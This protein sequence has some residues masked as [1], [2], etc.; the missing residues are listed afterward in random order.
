[1]QVLAAKDEDNA[2]SHA[3]LYGKHPKTLVSNAARHRTRSRGF[4]T[5]HKEPN[6]SGA[7]IARL[8]E[9]GE[10]GGKRG[11]QAA[12]GLVVF[13]KKEDKKKHSLIGPPSWPKWIHSTSRSSI[14]NCQG[15]HDW[16]VPGRA[17]SIR[18]TIEELKVRNKASVGAATR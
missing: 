15:D 10:H 18:N 13:K 6:A 5:N 4:G 9:L 1:M 8:E 11:T 12:S 2:A 14:A 16:V 7:E 17:I 3:G